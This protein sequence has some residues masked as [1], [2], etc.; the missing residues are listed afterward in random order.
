MPD[1]PLE[2]VASIP[3]EQNEAEVLILQFALRGE[4]AT[5]GMATVRASFI[6]RLCIDADKR[7]EIDPKGLHIRQASIIGRLD[8]DSTK[9]LFP[10]S[11][12]DCEIPE[13]IDL[14]DAET[15]RLDIRG[16]SCGQIAAEGVVV[17]G[18]FFL[19]ECRVSAHSDDDYAVLNLRTAKIDGDLSCAGA[20]FANRGRMAIWADGLTV[21]GSVL[22]NRGFLA[23][24]EVGLFGAKINGNFDCEAAQLHNL[25]GTTIY[26][27]KA[28]FGANVFFRNGFTTLGAIRLHGAEIVGN[29]EIGGPNGA[30]C[31]L[32]ND[33]GDVLLGDGLKVGGRVIFSKSSFL[34]RVSLTGA[35][36]A[37]SLDCSH[38]RF[39]NNR[40]PSIA[41]ERLKIGG[42]ATFVDRCC[43]SGE[44]N[45]QGASIGGDLDLADA[46]L[47]SCAR[48]AVVADEAKID[49]SIRLGGGSYVRGDL[50]FSGSKIGRNFEARNARSYGQICL[51]GASISGN[52]CLHG[53]PSTG[54]SSSET[55]GGRLVNREGHTLLV[56]Q[57]VIG[58]EVLIGG[59]AGLTDRL[60]SYGELSLYGSKIGGGFHCTNCLLI[61]KGQSAIC[62]DQ[63]TFSSGATIGGGLQ[64]NGVIS[65]AGAAVTGALSFAQVEFFGIGTT[66]LTATDVTVTGTL[67]LSRMAL[68]RNTNIKLSYTTVG[69]FRDDLE[70]WPA[71]GNLHLDGFTYTAILDQIQQG[72]QR[73]CWLKRDPIFHPQ[74]YEQLARTLR[75][76]G[77]EAY[78]K[79][80]GIAKEKMRRKHGGLSRKSQLWSRILYVTIGYGYKPHWALAWSAALV[81]SASI[82][83]YFGHERDLMIPTSES[84]TSS[85]AYKLFRQTPPHYISFSAPIY[86]LDNF[87]PIVSLRQKENWQPND[88]AGCSL[89]WA[90][91]RCGW[92]LRLFV[93]IE[94]LLGWMLTTLWVAGLTG[95]VR[96][97]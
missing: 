93:W 96:K 39:L 8:L 27:S 45:L 29:L 24:G 25:R 33:R 16:S 32:A 2:L 76:S 17:R 52:L 3:H 56:N 5:C 82:V 57:A 84:V 72:R 89:P 91:V 15:R 11:L 77:Q 4:E 71:F 26:A 41:A 55:G 73:L 35:S 81:L 21:G 22:F 44:F 90:G 68:T 7:Q 34:G 19:D 59:K 64:T 54:D 94:T 74:P 30:I 38:C 62:L 42:S 69:Q 12:I 48:S 75:N 78:A 28:K 10:L 70:S 58:G 9:L 43:V 36:I 87:L 61:S 6:R 79:T 23:T 40:G 1:Q 37:S 49:G 51:T 95:L 65:L 13:G 80:V 50:R 14:R 88:H 46:Q 92:L 20:Q 67:D 18:G 63:A 47:S 97:E 86:A 31:R 83:F 85:A 53:G 66:G 60:R